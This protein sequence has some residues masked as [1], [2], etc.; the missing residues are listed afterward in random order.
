MHRNRKNIPDGPKSVLTGRVMK[1]KPSFPK[2]ESTIL[3][4]GCHQLQCLQRDSD[5][6]S[7][8]PN[9]CLDEYEQRYKFDSR[10]ACPVCQ[11]TCR[12]V[13][14]TSDMHKI[15]TRL[16]FASVNKSSGDQNHPDTNV[17]SL[18][19]KALEGGI[20]AS[21]SESIASNNIQHK[22]DV[23]Y[24][25]SAHEML[26]HTSY[27]P[28]HERTDIG[29]LLGRDTVNVLPSGHKFDTR[30]IGRKNFHA[31]NNSL[32][33]TS[34]PTFSSGMNGYVDIDY[35]NISPKY[36]DSMTGSRH[37]DPAVFTSSQSQ[38]HSSSTN[39][40]SN[41]TPVPSVNSVVDVSSNIPKRRLFATNCHIGS[42]NDPLTIESPTLPAKKKAKITSPDTRTFQRFMFHNGR[43][44]RQKKIKNLLHKRLLSLRCS[45]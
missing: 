24:G 45:K 19:T 40:A 23:A 13:Y 8:C 21:R 12:A 36:T 5:L 6:G 10:C 17:S 9:R 29:N 27:L 44:L 31:R 4:C 18:L 35:S 39:H 41:V 11:C 34:V 14:L 43:E 30:S 22:I 42:Q 26:A 3:R 2:G 38:L 25:A 28:I 15:A 32:V 7:T 1:R 37:R 33:G 16:R 20:L